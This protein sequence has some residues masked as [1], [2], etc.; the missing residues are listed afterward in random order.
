MKPLSQN[1]R[2]PADELA[3]ALRDLGY[4]IA[5]A[6]GLLA[7]CR[8]LGLRLKPWVLDREEASGGD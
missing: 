6:V 3:E 2:I 7:L 1:D 4:S 5:K 8:R